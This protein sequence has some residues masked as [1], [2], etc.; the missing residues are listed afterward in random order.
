MILLDAR[1]RA[2][3]ILATR[4]AREAQRLDTHG[5]HA[6]PQSRTDADATLKTPWLW[7]ANSV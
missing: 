6:R 4:I 7:A 2:A 3:M 1:T 5:S